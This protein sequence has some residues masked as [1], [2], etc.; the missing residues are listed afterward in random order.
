[1]S[2]VAR[3]SWAR[4]PAELMATVHEIFSGIQGEGTCVGQR[5]VFVRFSGCHANCRYCDT[6]AAREQTPL[7]ATVEQSAG[8][9]VLTLVPNPMGVRQV[10]DYVLTLQQGYPH[11]A[12]SLTGGEPLCQPTFVGALIRVLRRAGVRTYLETN[13]LLP[14]AFTGLATTPDYVAMDIKLPSVAGLGPQW[15]THAAFLT[16]AVARTGAAAPR[17]VQVKVVFGERCLKDVATAAAL[18]AGIHKDI[19]FILQPLTARPEGPSAP[20]PETVL[21]AQARAAHY[22]ADVRVIPQTHVLL[23]QW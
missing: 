22:L 9:R 15:E 10:R 5:Q 6:P 12:V 20:G 21:A 11:H 18:V 4:M 23:G 8:S 1:M 17:R 19:P 14:E 7:L 2:G 13:G 3:L 16:A